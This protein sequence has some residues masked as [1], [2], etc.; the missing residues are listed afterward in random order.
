[1]KSAYVVLGIPG[2][3]STQEVEAAYLKSTQYY[4]RERLVKDESA[5]ARLAEI[6]EAYK[7]L[8]HAE[9]RQ[10]HDRKLSASVNRSAVAAPRV[11]M[12]EQDAPWFSKPLQLIALLVV[13]LFATGGYM[14]YSRQQVKK[15]QAIFELAQKKLEAEAAQIVQKQ[16]EKADA[17]RVRMVA[18]SER[19]ERQFRAESSYVASRASAVYSQQEAQANRQMENDQRNALQQARDAKNEERQRIYDAERRVAADK[20]RVRELCYQNY[21]RPDC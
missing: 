16:Q 4:S 7:L 2:N 8:T 12:V 3:A 20:Q 15:E 17:D 5:L 10:A 9:F 1:M 18:E 13:I 6:K 21:R 11:V 19:K 14:S